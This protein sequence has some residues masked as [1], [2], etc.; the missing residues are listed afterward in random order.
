MKPSRFT[1]HAPRDLAKALQLL[2]DFGDEAKVLAGG[3]SLLPL[4]NFRMAAPQHLVDINRLPDLSAP[5]RQ[6]DGW[7][8]PA[9]ARQRAVE[10]STEL[11]A[12]LPLLAQ[13]LDQVAHPQIRNRG[14]VC[15]SLAHGDAAAELPATMLA[16]GATMLLATR[17]G[18]R[19]VSVEDFFQFHLT[20]AI[21]PD[22]LLLEVRIDNLPSR[23][24]TS[25]QEFAARRG[26]FGIAGVAAVVSFTESGA[27]S[28]CRLA[29]S[30]VAP[31]PVRLT[32]TEQLLVGNTLEPD[33]IDEAGRT[34]QGEV[35]PTGDVHADAA[36]RRQLAGAL[37]K[38]ALRDVTKN[39]SL[40]HV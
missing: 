12:D 4:L 24:Y 31:T 15:G 26:D 3:Q 8:I 19:E 10:R 25:F 18:Q 13:A 17:E 36:Y 23:T 16:L 1:H 38:R 20:T 5:K 2:A 11:A 30:G 14:T 28:S 35:S 29:A 21:E 7:T 32:E 22:E 33:L 6:S 37:T 34:T 40:T 27:V 9:L 39:A